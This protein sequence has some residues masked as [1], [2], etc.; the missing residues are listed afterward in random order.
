VIHHGGGG[1]SIRQRA[2]HDAAGPRHGVNVGAAGDGEEA[3]EAEVG[4]ER[5]VVGIQQD[6]GGLHLAMDE[7]PWAALVEVRK[8]ARRTLGDPQS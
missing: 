1:P 7:P 2:A 6:V 5:V 8:P 3:S 4:D